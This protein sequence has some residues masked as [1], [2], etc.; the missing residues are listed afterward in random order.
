[1]HFTRS[2][3]STSVFLGV[4][5]LGVVMGIAMPDAARG[6]DLAF[7]TPQKALGVAL[8]YRWGYI[9][10][11]APSSTADPQT[12]GLIDTLPDR[13]PLQGPTLG[14]SFGDF[15]FVAAYNVFEADIGKPAD[16]NRDGVPDTDVI[17]VRGNSASVSLLYQPIRHFFIGYGRYQGTLAFHIA[18]GG[19]GMTVKSQT[20]G[21]FYT[22][23]LAW[24]IDP[25][26]RRTQFF[27]SLYAAPPAS[28]GD[29]VEVN[30]YGVGLGAFF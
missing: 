30:S 15:G 14:M 25:T 22:I 13:I 28:V 5:L 10:V 7:L 19:K 20:S 29:E 6:Q 12:K 18:A 26:V 17:A 21:N 24:G 3:L 8:Y 27:F 23:A 11:Q 1:M 9:E 16:L 4:V 2:P